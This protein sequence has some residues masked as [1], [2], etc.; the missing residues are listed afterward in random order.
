MLQ[1]ILKT[2]VSEIDIVS[3]I[4]T[5]LIES[6]LRIDYN[7]E[8]A[9]VSA[10]AEA[11][12]QAVQGELNED[13]SGYTL[14]LF[15]D[16]LRPVFTLPASGERISISSA[17][18]WDKDGVQQAFSTS[19]FLF[20]NVGYPTYVSYVGEGVETQAGRKSPFSIEF[21]VSQ[22]EVQTAIKQAVLLMMGHLYENREM[23][24]EGRKYEVPKSVSYL[25]SQYKKQAARWT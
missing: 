4:G 15:F 1:Q 17:N 22:G 16:V 23:V 6:H 18:Y 19:D 25:L 20:E 3:A 7:S 10:L 21:V 13:L 11:A 5:G 14:K 24:S 8:S 2:S 12:F 9:Y